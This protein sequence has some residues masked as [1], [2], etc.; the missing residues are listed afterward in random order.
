MK[1]LDRITRRS[2][3]PRLASAVRGLTLIELM[4]TISI[5]AIL[6]SIAVPSYRYVTNANRIS[7]EVNG[8]VGDLQFA[9]AQAIKE[10]RTVTVCS[11]TDGASCADSSSWHTG[12]IVFSDS[13]GNATVDVGEP[14]WRMQRAFSSSDTFKADNEI[15]SIKFNR[16][17]FAL[18]L[19][20]TVTLKLHDATNDSKWTRCVAISL[21]GVLTTQM[22]GTGNCT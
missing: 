19:P 3:G 12:W 10:G 8:L 4:I 18:G 6:M 5:V 22:A 21:V 13:N 15:Q 20:G 7:S 2:T 9:R 16:E 1:H 11:S 17:G 14:I